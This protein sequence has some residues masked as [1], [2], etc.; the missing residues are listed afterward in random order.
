MNPP[1]LEEL[2]AQMLAVARQFH[3]RYT[4]TDVAMIYQ[5]ESLAEWLAD[6]DQEYAAEIEA[7]IGQFADTGQW[8][9]LNREQCLLI[10]LRAQHALWFLRLLMPSCQGQVVAMPIPPLAAPAQVGWLM[11]YVW[12]Q[13]P[14]WHYAHQAA[15]LMGKG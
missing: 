15:Q 2:A 1:G 7:A 14:R 11:Q 6:K 8:P 5:T 12:L 9:E 13:T 3:L 10:Y 4:G